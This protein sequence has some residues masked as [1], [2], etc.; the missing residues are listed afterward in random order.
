MHSFFV[1]WYLR[2]TPDF[3]TNAGCLI[4]EVRTWNAGRHGH[5]VM[6]MIMPMVLVGFSR[7]C[8]FGIL[9]F[10][11]EDVTLGLGHSRKM[12]CKKQIQ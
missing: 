6:M 12:V 4:I 3:I 10:V 5:M 11:Q 7:Q 2:L 8:M 9:M 1:T